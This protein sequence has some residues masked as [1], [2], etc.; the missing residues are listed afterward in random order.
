MITDLRRGMIFFYKH[1]LL[2]QFGECETKK[3]TDVQT[4]VNRDRG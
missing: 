4:Y 1:I 2:I 3:H